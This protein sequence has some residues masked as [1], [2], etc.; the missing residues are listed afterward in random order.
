[1]TKKKTILWVQENHSVI[2]W[3][4]LNQE[5]SPFLVPDHRP[6]THSHNERLLWTVG[7]EGNC[8]QRP[9]A[10][11]WQQSHC[12]NFRESWTL[13]Q[14]LVVYEARQ[15]F[16]LPS[17]RFWWNSRSLDCVTSHFSSYFAFGHGIVSVLQGKGWRSHKRLVAYAKW[18]VSTTF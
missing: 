12:V 8:S 18:V 4:L 14:T 5:W 2:P 3:V 16:I 9:Q 6:S 7:E 15:A 1:M 13:R 17:I 11:E 10:W